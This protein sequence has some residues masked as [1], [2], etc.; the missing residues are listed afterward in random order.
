MKH[1]FYN[2]ACMVLVAL[3]CLC[4]CQED[5]D[6][7]SWTGDEN[8]LLLDLETTAVQQS[9]SAGED[10][11][12]ENKVAS[13]DVFFFNDA[14][15][16]CIYAQ[17]G[18]VPDGTQL[19]VKLDNDKVKFGGSY[20]IYVIANGR[21]YYAD[22]T[23]E[24][25]VGQTIAA[26]KAKVIT[27]A[28][29]DGY[30]DTG[31]E[32]EESLLMD[33]EANV[34]ISKDTPGKVKLTRA[35]AKVA[36]F[37]TVKESI[38]SNGVIYTPQLENMSVTMVYGV[39]STKLDGTYQVLP[40]DY[41][42]RMLRKYADADVDGAYTHV[43]FYSYPNPESTA[44]RQDTYLILCVPWSMQ[45][46]SGTQSANYYYR[47]PITGDVD[48][49]AT[50]GRNQYYK[51]NVNVG[52]LG[53]LNPRDAVELK[54]NFAIYNWFTMELSADMQHYEYLVLDEYSSVMNNENELRMPY[55]S[56]SALTQETLITKVTYPNYNDRNS[57]DT[58]YT[59]TVTLDASDAE[60]AGFDLTWNDDELIFTHPVTTEDYVPYTITVEVYNEQG[61]SAT[62]EI[63]QYPAIYIVGDYNPDGD[64]NRFIYGSND[65]GGFFGGGDIY[66]DRNNDLG[67]VNNPLTSGASNSNLNQYTIYITSFDI[68]GSNYAIG[69]PRSST[70]DNLQYLG[71]EDSQGRSLTY[72]YPTR[73]TDVDNV[74]APA[75]KI[76]SSWGVTNT[77]TL[78]YETAQRRCA[79]YQEN[80]Y[81]A[82]R[83][84]L[85]TEAEIEYIVSLSNRG[86]IPALFN[87]S[88]YAS[89]R[90]YYDN[91]YYED[92]PGFY[93][94]Q[95]GKVVRC[96]YDVWYWGNE[97]L[98]EKEGRDNQFVWGD[99]QMR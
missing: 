34:T 90:R 18:L 32:I 3:G 60:A 71:D 39:K 81:P 75:F 44:D 35:M 28:W 45:G 99:E 43:P 67:G 97:K 84:R 78:S 62:W 31:T 30:G 5:L 46:E 85:P 87:G 15:G 19:R 65:A 26:L 27:T 72:Y 11:Y 13:A 21:T 92:E 98:S 8:T 20:R 4:A 16:Q 54:G 70:P 41:V 55:I 7:A 80:G 89:S 94:Y 53:S 51:V 74:I 58:G 33:G 83:W 76:A 64:N 17:T 68:E 36:L 49:P 91:G 10:D 56:S 66:D 88:Y 59:S 52:V 40:A 77:N 82:G 38:E 86:V 69:D 24:T 22:V 93:P 25:A 23:N 29:K 2:I 37:P 57:S 61:L 63:T 79:S 42:N 9:R 1:T 95:S 6:N 73:E 14:T 50:L 96:V 47:V 12:N 48:V